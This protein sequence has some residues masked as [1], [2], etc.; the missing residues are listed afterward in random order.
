MARLTFLGG[1]GTVTG[2]CFLLE[3]EELKLLVDCGMFQGNR[4]LRLRNYRRMETPV[5]SLDYILLTHAHIDHSGL[6]PRLCCQGFRGKV[7]ATRATVELCGIM[8]PDSG[9][10]QEMESEWES[11]KAKRRGEKE[12][13]PLYTAQDAQ[14]CLKFFTG[15]SYGQDLN[16]GDQ[17]RV[18]F[19]DAG[20]IL[21]SAIIE[22]WIREGQAEVKLVFSGDLGNKGTPIVRDPS[23][24]TEADFLLLE[25][26]YGDRW[27][28]PVAGE[29][30][31][32]REIILDTVKNGGNVIIPSFAVGRTQ[33]LLFFLREMFNRGEL[34][35]VPVYIDSPLAVSATEIFTRCPEYYDDEARAC[36]QSG[37]PFH[38]PN[39]F[40][41]RDTKESIALNDGDRQNGRPQNGKRQ[42]KVIISASGM[43]D[44]GRIKHHLKHNLWRPE[45]AVV[46]VGF[47]AEGT[48]GRRIMDGEKKV[49]VLG[50]PIN[51][52][53]KIYSLQGF[54]AHADQ[55]GLLDWVGCLQRKPQRLFIVHGEAA[56]SATLSSL[57]EQRYGIATVVPRV[58]EQYVL[59]REGLELS[60]APLPIVQP[61]GLEVR[62]RLLLEI[63]RLEKQ[64]N[65][66]K[67]DLLLGEYP[68]GEAAGEA[69]VA[70][71]AAGEAR[72]AAPGTAALEQILA[73]LHE[74]IDT[75]QRLVP[76]KA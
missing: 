23:P 19:L 34:P 11:R 58:G 47:Q 12:L 53:A 44:A 64:M 33:E 10:I 32:L 30:G 57:V 22:V 51:V 70:G 48:L 60:R 42:S 72:G 13:K 52:A 65:V 5:P 35:P 74:K 17:V 18:R 40:F 39:L 56:A 46:F 24:I 36:F 1:A 26:T 4:E 73:E 37:D 71:E 14:N 29:A 25:S 6:I 7:L 63:F 67:E 61:A 16:L 21:G 45:S 28:Q 43:C 31:R 49:R 69:G 55:N 75:L 50:E 27:H 41:V 20:H 54:S 38:F 76:R 66:I 59:G 8:L 3:T 15:V 68:P 62:Q 9:H 2:S